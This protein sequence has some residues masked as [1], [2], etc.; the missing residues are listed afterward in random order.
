MNGLPG[1][2][3]RGVRAPLQEQELQSGVEA[4]DDIGI[5][6]VGNQGWHRETPAGVVAG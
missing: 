2:A 4:A 1:V 6:G 5:D 3:E